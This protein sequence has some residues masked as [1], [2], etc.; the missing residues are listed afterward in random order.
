M[1]IFICMMG[2]G[3]VLKWRPFLHSRTTPWDKTEIPL[4]V[5]QNWLKNLSRYLPIW[6][7]FNCSLRSQQ[8]AG[9]LWLTRNLHKF[10]P[11]D[12]ITRFLLRRAKYMKATCLKYMEWGGVG[13]GERVRMIRMYFYLHCWQ[14]AI[15]CSVLQFQS[16]FVHSSMNVAVV[17]YQT[18]LLGSV[19]CACMFKSSRILFLFRCF[20]NCFT[21]F[22]SVAL[23]F[24]FM[25]K[26][27]INVN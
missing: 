27:Q 24:H 19:L 9:L 25:H 11:P 26:E 17:P 14:V 13:K 1:C 6:L 21:I 22:S 8:M 10:A 23:L 7:E 20:Q 18:D 4:C 5:S 15:V 12:V 3:E 16:V 2:V